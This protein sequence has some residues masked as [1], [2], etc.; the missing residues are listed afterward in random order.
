[1]PFNINKKFQLL[2]LY[3]SC[4]LLCIYNTYFFIDETRILNLLIL[5]MLFHSGSFIIYF[6]VLSNL[7]Y[8]TP[9]ILSQCAIY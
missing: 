8:V 3:I 2:W 6:F 5:A 1:M 7:Y 9:Y 4:D